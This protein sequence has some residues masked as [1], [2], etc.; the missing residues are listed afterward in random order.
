MVA[1]FAISLA[2][3]EY[4]G[5]YPVDPPVTLPGVPDVLEDVQSM[6]PF[7]EP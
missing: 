5:V 2:L 3:K 7:V 1:P 4:V 6:V